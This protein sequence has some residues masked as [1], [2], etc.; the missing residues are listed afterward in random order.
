MKY[1]AVAVGIRD[2]S[3]RPIQTFS[4]HEDHVREW[5]FKTALA[6]GVPVNIWVLEDRLLD[7]VEAPAKA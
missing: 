1:R 5:A 4:A 6:R 3:D 2:E 7:T